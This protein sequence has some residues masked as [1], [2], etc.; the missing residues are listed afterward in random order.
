[1]LNG[2]KLATTSFGYAEGL[3]SFHMPEDIGSSV[4]VVYVSRSSLELF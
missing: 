2:L 3:K 4:P 1:M